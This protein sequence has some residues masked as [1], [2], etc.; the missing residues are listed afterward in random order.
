[1]RL[2]RDFSG[3]VIQFL[4]CF[5]F[6][7]GI[8]LQ[9]S[10]FQFTLPSQALGDPKWTCATDTG[11]GEP[12]HGDRSADLPVGWSLGRRK[13]G[14]RGARSAAAGPVFGSHL[15]ALTMADRLSSGC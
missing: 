6:C 15:C 14:S 2:A 1:M 9:I 4:R 5:G 10:S 7:R 12:H 11:P 13:L 8:I 3:F